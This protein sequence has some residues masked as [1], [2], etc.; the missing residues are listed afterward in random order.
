MK[1]DLAPGWQTH[2]SS[3][4]NVIISTWAD[5]Q[6]F[7]FTIS[8]VTCKPAPSGPRDFLHAHVTAALR[9]WS[10]APPYTNLR[11]GEIVEPSPGRFS[12]HVDGHVQK[13]RMYFPPSPDRSWRHTVEIDSDFAQRYTLIAPPGAHEW[14]LA[15][16][17][18][19]A[20]LTRGRAEAERI[21]QSL[22]P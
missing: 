5:E 16:Y 15:S 10:A 22:A 12:A 13:G 11:M 20:N 4:G 9:Q 14:L 6:A 2:K 19:V 3:D 18:D 21:V 17:T 7:E 8:V 1:I